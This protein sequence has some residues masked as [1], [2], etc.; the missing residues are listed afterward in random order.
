MNNFSSR[1]FPQNIRSFFPPEIFAF[2]FSQKFHEIFVFLFFVKISHFLRNRSKRNFRRNFFFTKNA[3][4]S[5]NDLPFSLEI[6][7]HKTIIQAMFCQVTIWHVTIFHLTIFEADR[8]TYA[9]WHFSSWP[10][11]FDNLLGDNGC[12]GTLPSDKFAI[13]FLQGNYFQR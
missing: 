4:L 11:P 10:L 12:S 7:W 9:M 13:N 8:W 3:K 6:F 2:V 1:L 5:R